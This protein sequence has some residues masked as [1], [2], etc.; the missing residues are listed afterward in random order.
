MFSIEITSA[1]HEKFAGCKLNRGD[2]MQ[3]MMR[4]EMM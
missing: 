1:K 4:E 2:M 3:F